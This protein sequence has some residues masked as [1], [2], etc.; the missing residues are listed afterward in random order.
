MSYGLQLRN[1]AGSVVFD[2]NNSS[3][4]MVYRTEVNGLAH[5]ATVTIPNFDA[6]KGVVWMYYMSAV[7]ISIPP[8]TVS[9]NVVSFALGTPSGYVLAIQAVMFA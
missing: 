8:Y 2:S 1:S 9:G 5:G 3:L 6:S 4:R 7:T